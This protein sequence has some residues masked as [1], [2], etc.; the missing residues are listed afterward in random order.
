MSCVSKR[1]RRLCRSV[2]HAL[3]A[4]PEPLCDPLGAR[5]ALFPIPKQE[6][7]LFNM[8]KDAYELFWSP[9]N[10]GVDYSHERESWAALDEAAKTFLIGL[11]SF[12]VVS[13]GVIADNITDNFTREFT[14]RSILFFFAF[15]ASMENTHS[16]TYSLMIDKAV[17]DTMREKQSMYTAS[18]NWEKFPHI[19]QKRAW[20]KRYT[21]RW[22]PLQERLVAF[23]CAEGIGFSSAFAG[24][25]WIREQYPGIF[26]ALT[27]FNTYIMKD[28]NMHTRA[29]CLYHNSLQNRCSRHVAHEIIIEAVD[30]EILFM[31]AIITDDAIGLDRGEMAEYIR[32]IADIMCT[33]LVDH[34]GEQL[35]PIYNAKNPFPW[36]LAQSLRPKENFFEY[37]VSEY[38]K[39]TP[40]EVEDLVGDGPSASTFNFDSEI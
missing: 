28:E 14:N 18:T 39:R 5:D 13:D 6:A 31:N 11:L 10:S 33:M 2:R 37:H 1:A 3:F 26:N 17:P 22:I 38:V 30:L 16:W 25:F 19:A 7:E 8:F 29:G 12:F 36:M 21:S 23:A 15:Q 32:Y 27:T 9:L 40:K 4:K 20:M 35:P 24:M 34:A